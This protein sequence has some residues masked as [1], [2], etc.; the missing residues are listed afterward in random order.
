MSGIPAATS[1][2]FPL[3][4]VAP[5]GAPPC[6]KTAYIIRKELHQERRQKSTMHDYRA[7]FLD[8]DGTLTQPGHSAPPASAVAAIESARRLGRRVF[9]CTGRCEAMLKPLLHWQWRGGG[10]A[11]RGRGLSIGGGGRAGEGVRGFRLAGISGAFPAYPQPNQPSGEGDECANAPA[12]SGNGSS[13]RVSA[14]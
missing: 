2:L 13:A 4:L 9:L 14:R 11:I 3:P 12:A 10:K 6:D 5:A 7:I 1:V 8:I